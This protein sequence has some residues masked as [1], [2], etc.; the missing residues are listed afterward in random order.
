MRVSSAGHAESNGDEELPFDP[1][2]VLAALALKRHEMALSG[3]AAELAFSWKVMGGTWTKAHLGLDYDAFRAEARSQHA[4]E[5]VALYGLQKS[6]SF[7]LALYGDD[8]AKLL[9]GYWCD[10]MVHFY[11]IW[12]SSKIVGHVFSDVEVQ[13][14]VEPKAFTDV[15]AR[16]NGKIS[17]RMRQLR[18]LCP[19]L[20]HK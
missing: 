7:T 11:G 15:F 18:A 12:S 4:K 2:A 20:P 13:S 6:A 16:A 9:A 1:K 14:F 17:A 8:I 5:F 3:A 10:K 19:G